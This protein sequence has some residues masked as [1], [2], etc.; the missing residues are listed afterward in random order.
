M[1]RPSSVSEQ[2]PSEWQGVWFPVSNKMRGFYKKQAVGNDKPLILEEA[3]VGSPHHLSVLSQTRGDC[4]ASAGRWADPEFSPKEPHVLPGGL[5]AAR[6][7]LLGCSP[8]ALLLGGHLLTLLGESS[9][10]KLPDQHATRQT[11]QTRW[12][13]AQASPG[14]GRTVPASRSG[15]KAGPR[16]LEWRGGGTL[17]GIK[18]ER[19]AQSPRKGQGA[20]SPPPECGS[21]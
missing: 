4:R 7:L 20:P 17:P 10:W 19:R 18:V 12:R 11:E 15:L 6:D 8:S 2:P 9:C 21:G 3:S 5:A 1:G 16:A 13:G 14:P